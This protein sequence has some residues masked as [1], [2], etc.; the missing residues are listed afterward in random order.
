MSYLPDSSVGFVSEKTEQSILKKT[1]IYKRPDTK[2]YLDLFCF[3]V[4]FC[5]LVLPIQQDHF[6]QIIF[7]FQLWYSNISNVTVVTELSNVFMLHTTS[8]IHFCSGIIAL[9]V[10]QTK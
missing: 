3:R 10:L 7:R 4:S 8:R 2:T 6:I 9:S 5:L 1:R